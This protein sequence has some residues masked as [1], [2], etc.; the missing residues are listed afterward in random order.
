MPLCDSHCH[1]QDQRLADRSEQIIR[2]ALE[3]GVIRMVCCGSA[4]ED[5]EAVLNLSRQF[6]SVI[7]A[8]GVHPWYAD[9]LPEHWLPLLSRYLD[10]PGA[11]MG[12]IGLDNKYTT[13][14][15]DRQIS[16]FRQQVRLA[17][18]RGIP[19]SLHCVKAWHL[20]T[21]VLREFA[22]SG[23]KSQI[24]SYGGGPALVEPLL[25]LNV[26]FS[27]SGSLTRPG[28]KKAHEAIVRIPK[29]RL[30]LETDAPDIPLFINGAIDYSTPN[31]PANLPV[32]LNHAALL[33]E[34]NKNDLEILIWGN[35]QAFLAPREQE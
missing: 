25:E 21:P 20:L 16:I 7:P 27:F 8:F 19:V 14:A 18:E 28:N 6:P 12:E 1:L 15:M 29:D 26:W 11:I 2:R 33:L 24:H 31:E 22:S 30:L 13:I 4:P 9:P 35:S 32:I 3:A 23:L 5:W 10:H 34:M 17:A